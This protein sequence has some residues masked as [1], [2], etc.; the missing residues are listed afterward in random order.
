M[1]DPLDTKIFNEILNNRL[2]SFYNVAVLYDNDISV[3]CN[4]LKKLSN[5]SFISIADEYTK[6][7]LMLC[8]NVSFG[9][10][11]VPGKS[12]KKAYVKI[13]DNKFAFNIN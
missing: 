9:M 10:M 5:R 4:D 13:E 8:S 7:P 6:S 12:A 1:Q 11:N 2:C 3:Y